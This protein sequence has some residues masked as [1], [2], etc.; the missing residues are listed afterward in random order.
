MVDS[1]QLAKPFFFIDVFMLRAIVKTTAH[2][3]K[4]NKDNEIRL[5]LKLISTAQGRLTFLGCSF[6]SGNSIYH[7]PGSC[8]CYFDI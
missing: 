1:S 7:F 2:H 6:Y 4:D 8:W 5:Q 3:S